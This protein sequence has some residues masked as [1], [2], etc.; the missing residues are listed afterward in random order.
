M[1]DDE[2]LSSFSSPMQDIFLHLLPKMI[3]YRPIQS[4]RS[5]NSSL[6]FLVLPRP[7]FLSDVIEVLIF[8]MRN[9]R[10]VIWVDDIWD[11][12]QFTFHQSRSPGNKL[13]LVGPLG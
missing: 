8:L 10:Q 7:P 13:K 3:K 6:V 1:P 12:D 11:H 5:F 2:I 9:R 4:T